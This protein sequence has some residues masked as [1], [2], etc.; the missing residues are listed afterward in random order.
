MQGANKMLRTAA[1]GVYFLNKTKDRKNIKSNGGA[2]LLQK[3]ILSTFFSL[4]SFST[5]TYNRL[6]TR[7]KIY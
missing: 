1:T 5:M 3:K 4:I 2:A 7:F 6:K